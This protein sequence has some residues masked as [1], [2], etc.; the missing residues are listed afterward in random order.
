MSGSPESSVES[1]VPEHRERLAE[2]GAALERGAQR[3]GDRRVWAEQVRV[4]ATEVINALALHVDETESEGGLYAEI[5]AAQ[6]RL[7]HA[8]DV[9]RKDHDVLFRSAGDLLVL[10]AMA[11]VDLDESRIR[12]DA[13]DLGRAIEKHQRRGLDL[14]YE[15]YEV[16]IGIGE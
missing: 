12:A 2:A 8:I 15:F 11:T 4:A 14:L 3:G 16:D 13:S 5:M 10:S 9:L 1:A 7:A 6:P